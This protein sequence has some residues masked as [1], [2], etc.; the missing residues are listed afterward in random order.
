M[1]NNFPTRR[2]ACPR[3][4]SE[5][6][7]VAISSFIGATVVRGAPSDSRFRRWDIKRSKQLY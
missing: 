3:I 7:S 2:G 5:L 4:S 1:E 6:Q